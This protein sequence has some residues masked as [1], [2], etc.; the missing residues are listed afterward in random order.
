MIH[1]SWASTWSNAIF[2][3]V[4]VA[5]T[6]TPII[7]NKSINKNT[8]TNK[9]IPFKLDVAVFLGAS[10]EVGIEE[11]DVEAGGMEET[12]EGLEV[13][14]VEELEVVVGGWTVEAEEARVA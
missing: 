4:W 10:L 3:L 9:R 12:D 7:K 11:T 5:T 6:S 1:S 8:K 14:G 2:D 13:E